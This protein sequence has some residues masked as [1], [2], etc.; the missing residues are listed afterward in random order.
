MLKARLA[1]L[2]PWLVLAWLLGVSGLTVRVLGG[3]LYA[4]RL[5]R[6]ENHPSESHWR[7]RLEYLSERLRL[8]QTVR[9]LESQMVRVPTTVGWLR[10]VILLPAS[11]FTGLTPQQLESVLAHE[12]AH[13]RRHDYLVNLFQVLAETL[14][15]YHPAA[16][17]VSGQVRI[18]REHACDDLAVSVCGDPIAYARALTTMERLRRSAPLLAV[19]ADGGKLHGRIRRLLENPQGVRGSSPALTGLLLVAAFFTFLA[20]AHGV[21]SQ[22]RQPSVVAGQHESSTR[23][24]AAAESLGNQAVTEERSAQVVEAAALIARDD[25]EGEDAEARRVA[26]GALGGRAGAVVVMDPRTGRVY[27]VVNQEWAVRR[28]WKPGSTIK[29]VTGA[30]A[31]GEKTFELPGR[32]RVSARAKALELTEALARSDNSYFLQLGESVGAERIISYA[33]EF[34]LGEPTGINYAG[35]SAGSIPLT[36]VGSDASR[37]GAYGEGIEVTPMQLATLVSSIANGGT[38]V[39]PRV[40]RA[41][42]SGGEFAPQVRR[43]L[44]IPRESFEQLMPGMIA[45][46]KYGTG[47]AASGGTQRVAGKTGS[48]VDDKSPVGIFASYAPADDPR[49]VVVVFTRGENESGRAAAGVAGE[50]YRAFDRRR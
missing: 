50:I 9:L 12:L 43:R 47:R 2:L 14:L 38:L 33:R 19:A 16:W 30:A 23:E 4:R 15:F 32:A 22:K 1:P 48:F 36:S 45:A 17:W 20:C 46:V 11:A 18:E 26:L 35:E 13:I 28:S 37:L 44:R 3:L 7:E 27:T 29:L 24:S 8:K 6:L 42:E 34:G 41:P 25:I 21:L 39:V 10:P 40:P 49:L 31:V 5:M